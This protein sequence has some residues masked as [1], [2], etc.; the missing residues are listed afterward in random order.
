MKQ[1]IDGM[2]FNPSETVERRWS[3]DNDD[4]DRR[5]ELKDVTRR[6][7]H[8]PGYNLGRKSLCKIGQE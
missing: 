4:V 8:A 3:I 2:R 1:F 6:K 7:P 5:G